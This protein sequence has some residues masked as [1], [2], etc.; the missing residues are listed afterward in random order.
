MRANAGTTPSPAAGGQAVSTANG[1]FWERPGQA[2]FIP[3]TTEQQLRAAGDATGCR[4]PSRRAKFPIRAARAHLTCGL[5][6]QALETHPP[7][8]CVPVRAESRI[9]LEAVPPWV[10]QYTSTAAGGTACGC[11]CA[12]A[13]AAAAA[14]AARL[15]CGAPFKSAAP[16]QSSTLRG[17]DCGLSSGLAQRTLCGGTAPLA[18]WLT[19]LDWCGP[20][21]GLGD[22]RPLCGPPAIAANGLGISCPVNEATSSA[23]A[24]AACSAATCS[25]GDTLPEAAAGAPAGACPPGAVAGRPC[26]S[27]GDC[28]RS[29]VRAGVTG[30][31]GGGVSPALLLPGP[32]GLPSPPSRVSAAAAACEAGDGWSAGGTCRNVPCCTASRCR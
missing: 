15:A 20:G 16:S 5:A 17:V 24:A 28:G 27:A 19:S 11:G 6:A 31:A 26:S 7:G 25:A 22:S 14:A 4:P 2:S 1:Q 10:R 21:E 9:M 12:T 32:A 30:V 23:A 29:A 18:C 8:G 13:C 3:H